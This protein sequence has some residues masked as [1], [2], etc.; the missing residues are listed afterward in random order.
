MV[1][2]LD[3]NSPWLLKLFSHSELR[4]ESMYQQFF[5]ENPEVNKC[6]EDI[7]NTIKLRNKMSVSAEP[8]M[9]THFLK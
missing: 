9:K 3:G 8:L 1:L 4:T 6:L 7:K 5:L 2:I